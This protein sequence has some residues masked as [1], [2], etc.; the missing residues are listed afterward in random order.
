MIS[1]LI[2]TKNEEQ[3]LPGC[4]DSVAWSDDIHVFDSFSTDRTVEIARARGAHVNQRVF[5]G[6][7]SQLNVALQILPFRYDWQLILDADE[8]VTPALAAE[9]RAAVTDHPPGVNAW[10][11]PIDYYLD[12][13]PLRHSQMTPVYLR[14]VRRGMVRWEREINPIPRVDGETRDLKSPID[15][16]PF[17]KGI[18]HWVQRHNSY[19]TMEA[20]VIASGESLRGA[21]VRTALFGKTYHERRAAKKALFYRMPARP[22]IKW[23]YMMFVQG[24]VLDGRAGLQYV[25]LQSI[26]EYL[27]VLKTREIL[28]RQA[29]RSEQH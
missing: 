6:Y 13:A 5:D 26:Y 20:E 21:S 8:R 28:R 4:L 24:A 25:N 2:L 14:L 23:L 15:H 7:A 16:F 11:I 22:L 1:V 19:S 10:R 18:A 3:D 9:M 12:D 27:I 17:S 29:T